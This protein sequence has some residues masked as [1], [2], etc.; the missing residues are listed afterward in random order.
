MH[1]LTTRIMRRVL[2]GSALCA[3]VY[4]VVLNCEW[5]RGIARWYSSPRKMP[6]GLS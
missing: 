5:L 6:F 2:L 1:S 3:V 4:V